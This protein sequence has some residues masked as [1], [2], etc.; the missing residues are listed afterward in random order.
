MDCKN[1]FGSRIPQS[2]KYH[3]PA[4]PPSMAQILIIDPDIGALHSHINQAKALGHEPIGA[5]SGMR[6]IEELSRNPEIQMIMCELDLPDGS[7]EQLFASVR[8]S[9]HYDRI[10]FLALSGAVES[11]RMLRLIATGIEYAAKKPIT[12][13]E[14]RFLIGRALKNHSD[15]FHNAE[16]LKP[17]L[18]G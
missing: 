8:Q 12:E 3:N 2:E 7:L 18:A 11:T 4:F 15:R 17:R 6:G 10:P 16:D 1:S 13:D 14:M 9:P 5:T